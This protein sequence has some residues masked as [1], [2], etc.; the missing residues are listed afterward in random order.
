MREIL[1]PLA[2]I[3]GV[4]T[5]VLVSSEGMPIAV[6]GKAHEKLYRNDERDWIDSTDDLNALAGLAVGWQKEATR[7]VARLSWEAPLRLVL[8]ANR[9]TLVMLNAPGAILLVVLQRNMNAEELRLPMKGA[10]ARMQR[11]LRGAGP[12]DKNTSQD[13]ESVPGIFPSGEGSIG[14]GAGE[15]ETTGKGSP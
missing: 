9:G 15:V 12:T 8:Q 6:R 3:P 4:R 1:E 10:V 13:L 2:R 5:A 7:S 11:V 14:L